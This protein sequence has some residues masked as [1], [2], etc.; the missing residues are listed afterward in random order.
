MNN[1][2]WGEVLT[3]VK[4]AAGVVL[5]LNS[6]FLLGALT[7]TIS[8]KEA[9]LGALAATLPVVVAYLKPETSV[10]VIPKR[11]LDEYDPSFGLDQG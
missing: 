6:A 4:Y 5:G 11:E 2:N 7:G 1:L 3:K 9:G 8:W 10:V